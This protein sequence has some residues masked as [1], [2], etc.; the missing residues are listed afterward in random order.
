M[1]KDNVKFVCSRSA[2]NKCIAASVTSW[3]SIVGIANF[4]TFSASSELNVITEVSI[5]LS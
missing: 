3:I 5:P 1:R 4:Q 2:I